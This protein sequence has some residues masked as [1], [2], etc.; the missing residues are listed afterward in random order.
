MWC[1]CN[2]AE[3]EPFADKA[4]LPMYSD[5][6]LGQK[7]VEPNEETIQ[8]FSEVEVMAQ[9]KA[10]QIQ[11][12]REET[13]EESIEEL[14][15]KKTSAENIAAEMEKVERTAQKALEA[16]KEN[17]KALQAMERVHEEYMTK[18]R[19]QQ[20][21]AES[22]NK[23]LQ[24]MKKAYEDKIK[25]IQEEQ[26]KVSVDAANTKKALQD[27]EKVHENKMKDQQV[28]NTKIWESMKDMSKALQDEKVKNRVMERYV[29]NDKQNKAE[30]KLQAQKAKNK[31]E[32]K[33]RQLKHKPPESVYTAALI[34]WLC[35]KC[36]KCQKHSILS[37]FGVE[38]SSFLVAGL[39]VAA[40]S[41]VIYYLW[42]DL[43]QRLEW[44]QD[45]TYKGERA[46]APCSLHLNLTLQ[47]I[48]AGA[49]VGIMLADLEE[50][51]MMFWWLYQKNVLHESDD[52][53]YETGGKN[54]LKVEGEEVVEFSMSRRRRI[55]GAIFCVLPKFVITVCLTIV[56][57]RFVVLADD[58]A[59][60]LLNCVAM[61]FVIDF[62]E[63]CGHD[64]CD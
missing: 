1:A 51:L 38:V 60:L 19:E 42:Y 24:D 8:K 47:L 6:E 30:E 7:P 46:I 11:E 41:F 62:D 16:Q 17:A 37:F 35:L 2:H 23:E 63:L 9:P 32:E 39:S 26:E 50:S 61:I 58:N 45:P 14:A 20:Q 48:G 56:G 53:G 13:E 44:G 12:S 40:Q 59:E 4:S 64:L 15:E 43:E 54:G 10:A 49:F 22:T 28:T 36:P 18:M 55:L 27:M 52:P 33:E 57:T 25:K 5:A 21:L 3:E 29:E 34:T 31:A